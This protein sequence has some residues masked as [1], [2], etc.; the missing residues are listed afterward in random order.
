MSKPDNDSYG[1]RLIGFILAF[2]IATVLIN[3]VIG[4]INKRDNWI[5]DLQRRVGQLESERR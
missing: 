3:V 5:R 1:P 2:V 4:E